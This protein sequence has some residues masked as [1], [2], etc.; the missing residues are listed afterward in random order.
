M[1]ISYPIEM[2][3]TLRGTSSWQFLNSHLICKSMVFETSKRGCRLCL[4]F[5]PL[6]TPGM[7]AIVPK[8]LGDRGKETEGSLNDMKESIH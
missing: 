7:V 8:A 1:K 6:K 4:E 5:Y 2:L 3:M